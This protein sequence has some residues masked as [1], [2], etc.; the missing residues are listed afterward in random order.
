MRERQLE[1]ELAFVRV[2]EFR[3]TLVQKSKE[4]GSEAMEEEKWRRRRFSL[5]NIFE[6]GRN[7]LPKS[8]W[9]WNL[10][11]GHSVLSLP[12]SAPSEFDVPAKS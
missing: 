11:F 12:S 5:R 10:R 8:E 3:W 7:N 1:S 6:I 9:P 2:L 4:V